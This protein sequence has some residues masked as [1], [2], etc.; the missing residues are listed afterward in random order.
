MIRIEDVKLRQIIPL[1]FL[2]MLIG[3]LLLS[4]LAFNMSDDTFGPVGYDVYPRWVGTRAFWRGESPYSAAVDA[5][6]QNFVY[7]RLAKPGEDSFGFYYPPHTAVV[8]L[9]LTLLP[10]KWAVAVWTS[11]LWAVLAVIVYLLVRSLPALPSPWLLAAILVTIFL[12]R[13]L[14]LSTING[15]YALFLTAVWG[16]AY[17]FIYRGH[18]GAAGALLALITI[19]PSLTFFPLLVLLGWAI[20][21]RRHKLVISFVLTSAAFFV[22]TL[23]QLGWW[24]PEFLAEL[25]EY[26][27]TARTWLPRDILTLPGL[28]WLI[29]SVLLMALGVWQ[30][31][32]ERQAFPWALFVGVISLNLLVTPHT[33]EYDLVML[34]LPFL[35]FAPAFLQSCGG[36]VSWFFLFWL[37]WFVWGALIMGGFS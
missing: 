36:K 31:R 13:S 9:P 16:A 28:V 35:F 26:G 15:Q 29:G 27:G 10:A 32:R 23:V 17:Y 21:N 5:E 2:F 12:S 3:Y 1:F 34:L 20:A 6:T 19:K 30:W 4:W 33:S 24:L 18:E 14:L 11:A 7:G 8:L 25:D 37:P 22:I